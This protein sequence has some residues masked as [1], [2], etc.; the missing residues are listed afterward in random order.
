MV[1]G[2]RI[3]LVA[4]AAVLGLLALPSLAGANPGGSVHLV[5]RSGRLVILHAD[6]T[7]GAPTRSWTLV[8][9][10]HHMPVRLPADAWV[11][12]GTPVRLEGTMEDGAL[13]VADSATGVR[14]IGRS[15]I[16]GTAHDL[17]AAPTMHSTVVI[18]VSFQGPNGPQW[19]SPANP[20]NA[21][22]TSLVFADPLTKPDSLNA[23]YLEQTYGQIGLQGS[24]VG[25]VP[26]PGD[27]SDCGSASPY[28]DAEQHDALYTWLDDAEHAA[29]VTDSAFQHVIVALPAGV[30]C[31]DV[32]GASGIAEL[33]GNHIWINGAFEV[34]VIAHEFGHNLGLAH[35]GGLECSGAT[36]SLQLG[37]NS[38]TTNTFEYS[39][40]FDAMGQ[41]NP[42][43]STMVLRQMSMQHKLALGLL[44]PSAVQ[45]VATPGSYHLAPMETLSGSVELLRITKGGGGS[46]FVEY[47]QPTGWF[48][49]Q[50]PSFAGVFVRTESPD[51]INGHIPPNGSDTA[52]VDMHPTTGV[53]N[54]PWADARM[55]LGQVFSDPLRGVTIQDVAEDASG[56]TLTITLPLDTTPPGSPVRLSATVSGRTVVLQWTAAGDDRGVASYS[57]A[58][59]G[60]VLGS[61]TTTTFTDS[62]IVQG[63]AATYAVTAT[64]LA[65]NVGPPATV[66]VMVPDTVAPSTPANVTATLSRDGRVHVAW[67]A[68]TDAGGVT[69]YRVLRNGTGI[70]QGNVTSYVDKAPKPGS[71]T[72]VTYSVVAF[73]LPGNASLPGTAKPLRAALLRSLGASRLSAVRA[74]SGKHKV[75]RVRG[76]VS[77]VQANCRL[78]LGRGKW[79][80]CKPKSSGGFD[81]KLPVNGAALV[82]LSLRDALGRVRLQTLRV[83]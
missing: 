71:G 48:D 23:Y 56:A 28:Y 46:Y 55:G 65:G 19:T 32:D 54:A 38:C 58:R 77:D 74:K 13:V 20:D 68:S 21:A 3:S 12:P 29:G 81:V 35:A 34:P 40:P 25:P 79:H 24:V 50:L 1:P 49:G 82:K 62:G 7:S 83:R 2:K 31:P 11:D 30:S 6:R 15:P 78:R 52:L 60:L 75:V 64:D 39:D 16:G 42:G 41:S 33:G 67:G 14:T 4:G 80:L 59:N 51:M 47:R 53:G 43:N 63:S 18:L 61:V 57:V 17:A 44:P 73:D 37:N 26:I 5:Q 72:G 45:V 70:F 66:T 9:G 76:T 8:T 36:A 27:G 22:A 10:A 69:S